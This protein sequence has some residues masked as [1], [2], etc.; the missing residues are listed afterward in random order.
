MEPPSTGR[1]T[2]EDF[3]PGVTFVERLLDTLAAERGLDRGRMVLVGFSQGAA[4]AFAVAREDRLRPRGIVALAGVLPDGDVGRLRGIPIFWGHGTQ[5]THVPI[6]AARADVE[7]LRR[8]G[9]S[10]QMCEADVEHRVGVECMR[11]LKQ[12]WLAHFSDEELRVVKG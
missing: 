7:R 2:F 10:V 5:D 6:E 9:A 1:S 12:W 4:L 3:R 11:G 8:V